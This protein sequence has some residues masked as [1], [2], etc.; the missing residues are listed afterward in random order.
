ME[1]L[2]LI[3]NSAPKKTV[4]WWGFSLHP[5]NIGHCGHNA[6]AGYAIDS[7]AGADTSAENWCPIA[8]CKQKNSALRRCSSTPSQKRTFTPATCRKA[9]FC[10]IGHDS[11]RLSHER[12]ELSEYLPLLSHTVIFGSDLY[13]ADFT[14]YAKND[15]VFRR[16][17]SGKQRGVSGAGFSPRY[18]S[19][20]STDRPCGIPCRSPL[21]LYSWDYQILLEAEHIANVIENG[22]SKE[23]IRRFMEKIMR[24]D[25]GKALTRQIFRV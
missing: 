10:P 24:I 3:A 23:N 12:R 11:R 4:T 1:K 8:L 2:R 5:N 14:D 19:F 17:A 13:D 9:R 6:N 18:R 22:Y 25:S 20:E 15:S 7:P 21:Y 16:K